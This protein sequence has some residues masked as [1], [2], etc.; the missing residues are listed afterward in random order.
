MKLLIT[1]QAID[2]KDDHFVFFLDWVR[3]FA[4]RYETVTVIALRTGS[5]TLP[6]NVEVFFAW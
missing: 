5:Y 6:K 1:T 2:E 4:K 3:E